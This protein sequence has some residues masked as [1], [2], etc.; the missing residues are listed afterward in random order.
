[1]AGPDE[2]DHDKSAGPEPDSRGASAFRDGALQEQADALISQPDPGAVEQWGARPAVL[3]DS[4]LREAEADCRRPWELPAQ[5]SRSA[6]RRDGARDEPASA[7][8]EHRAQPRAARLR[9][10]LHEKFV[11]PEK[12]QAAAGVVRKVSGPAWGPAARDGP[13]LECRAA[14]PGVPWGVPRRGL[15]RVRG[16]VLRHF[17]KPAAAAAGP[18]EELEEEEQQHPC[19]PRG[20]QVVEVP[21]KVRAWEPPAR[22]TPR[23][24]VRLRR[25][26]APIP[27]PPLQGAAI[28]S[29]LPSAGA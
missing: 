25:V 9:E 18:N 11:L 16:R 21:L 13:E 6:E 5:S 22:A 1:L 20:P 4:V 8:W 26:L 15:Q 14:R 29:V 19:E 3:Q 27:S 17:L 23:K 2:S 7:Y 24:T 10:P 28:R 12:G